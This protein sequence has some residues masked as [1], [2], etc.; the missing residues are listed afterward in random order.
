MYRGQLGQWAWVLHRVSGVAVALFLYVHVLDTA[1]VGFGP[2][3]YNTVVHIYEQPAVRVLELLLVGGVLYH[4]GN[5][6]RI[7]AI[8]FIPGAIQYNRQ[9]ILSG[10][11]LFVV[12]MIAVAY[13]MLKPFFF[14]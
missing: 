2:N 3:V 9:M 7:I 5:G 12:I 1:L 13:V 14:A 10:A 8:D 6:M 4:G 11:T